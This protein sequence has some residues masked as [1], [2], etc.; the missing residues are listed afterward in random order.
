MKKARSAW[1]Q[2]RKEIKDEFLALCDLRQLRSPLQE[3]RMMELAT[4]LDDMEVDRLPSPPQHLLWRGRR[5]RRRGKTRRL[6]RTSSHPS[7]GR[8]RRRQRQW[9]VCFSGFLVTFLFAL[10]FLRLSSTMAVACAGLVL[11]VLMHLALCSLLASPSPRCSRILA[12]M[13][14]KD[15]CTFYWQCM[16]KAC[17]A[18]LSTSRCVPLCVWQ[19]QMIGILAGMNQ[20]GWF[21]STAPRIW[22][23][24]FRCS[25][26]F[27]SGYMLRQSTAAFVGGA[28]SYSAQCLVRQWLWEMTS[29]SFSN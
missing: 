14:Q 17:F 8:A 28:F 5:R 21:L 18:G 7:P 11:P 23:S 3:R 12:G 20:K 13:D 22:Q 6:P 15:F 25:L 4:A 2:R 26:W 16:C 9:H 24:I 10:I 1:R 19:A 27:D 29:W